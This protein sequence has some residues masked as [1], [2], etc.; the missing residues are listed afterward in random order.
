MVHWLVTTG[1]LISAIAAVYAGARRGV[2]RTLATLHT[3]AAVWRLPECVESLTKVVEALTTEIAQL[4][5]AASRATPQTPE[6]RP[7]GEGWNLWRDDH[8]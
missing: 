1:A 5:A 7:F 8:R 3:A 2:R 6:H 4:R